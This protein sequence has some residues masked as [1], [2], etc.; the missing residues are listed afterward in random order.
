MGPSETIRQN[1]QPMVDDLEPYRRLVEIQKLVVKMA[2]EQEEARREILALRE[3]LAHEVLRPPCWRRKL[4][5]RIRLSTR[6][7]LQR[8]PRLTPIPPF[9]ALNR[10]QASC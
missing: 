3:Q 4:R 1:R 2:R 7:L 9:S 5:L 6:K 8:L 10:K